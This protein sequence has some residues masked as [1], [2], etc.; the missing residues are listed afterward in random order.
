MPPTLSEEIRMKAEREELERREEEERR[1]I[2]W[3]EQHETTW[4]NMLIH[5]PIKFAPEEPHCAYLQRINTADISNPERL[6]D[7]LLPTPNMI[8]KRAQ[9]PLQLQL[10]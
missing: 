9:T 8:L 3:K 1:Q 2:E 6:H 5:P 7:P 10:S 4:F